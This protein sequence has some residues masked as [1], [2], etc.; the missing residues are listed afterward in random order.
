M[1]EGGCGEERMSG[2]RGFRHTEQSLEELGGLF[3]FRKQLLIQPADLLTIYRIAG[4]VFAVARSADGDFAPP[5]R[6]DDLEMFI[7]NV[8]P[9]RAINFLDLT[10]QIHLSGFTSLNTQHAVRIE[11]AFCQRLTRLGVI[12]FF[13]KQTRGGRNIISL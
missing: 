7:V 12:T 9:L 11:R 8:L 4:Q 2:E 13:Y 3:A 10:Q 5:L 6:D 1:L